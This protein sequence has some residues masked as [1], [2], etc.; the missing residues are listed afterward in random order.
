MDKKLCKPGSVTLFMPRN[1]TSGFTE[2]G[3]CHPVDRSSSLMGSLHFADSE[4][5][6][7]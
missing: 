4:R 1:T 2:I 3:T 5:R 6:V 7:S